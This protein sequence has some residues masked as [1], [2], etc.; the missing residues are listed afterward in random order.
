VRD[1]RARLRPE[2]RAV[3]ESLERITAVRLKVE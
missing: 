2:T 1:G 3:A